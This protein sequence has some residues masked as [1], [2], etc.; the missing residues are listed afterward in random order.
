V[1]S[2][3]PHRMGR[4]QGGKGRPIL[5]TYS[6]KTAELIEMPFGFWALMGRRTR[7]LDGGPEV[8]REI[9]TL[10]RNPVP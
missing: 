2:R 6:A 9:L 8:L 4:F 10:N 1:G 7:V 3:F 5:Q